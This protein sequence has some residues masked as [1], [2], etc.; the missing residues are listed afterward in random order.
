MKNE[1]TPLPWWLSG[2][3]VTILAGDSGD[4]SVVATTEINDPMAVVDWDEVPANAKLIVDAVNNVLP[5]AN[6]VRA[7]LHL[8][9]QSRGCKG[10]VREFEAVLANW[11][12]AR[13]IRE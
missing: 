13:G 5:L 4:P 12:R 6:A 7:A 2:N 1:F 10:L 9:K 3:K 11:E 8:A